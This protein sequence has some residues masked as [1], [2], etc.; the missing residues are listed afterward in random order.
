LAVAAIAVARLRELGLQ[1]PSAL[2]GPTMPPSSGD[3]KVVEDAKVVYI[4]TEDPTKTVQIE[5]GL[6]P[7]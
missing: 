1:I 6:N 7:K 3:F 2:P 5:P 4:N